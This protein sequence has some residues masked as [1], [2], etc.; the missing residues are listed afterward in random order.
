MW[1][2]QGG[3]EDT[4]NELEECVLCKGS[5]GPLGGTHPFQ[6]GHRFLLRP[7]L[8]QRIRHLGKSRASKDT[9]MPRIIPIKDLDQDHLHEILK[10]PGCHSTIA[11]PATQ[12]AASEQTFPVGK[13][14]LAIVEEASAGSARPFG[15]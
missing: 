9:V 8:A 13:G 7:P 10:L 4:H 12:V 15:S 1:L 14:T 11:I 2:P 6:K 3:K 5:V